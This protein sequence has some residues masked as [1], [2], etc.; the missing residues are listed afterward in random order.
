MAASNILLIQQGV[1]SACASQGPGSSSEHQWCWAL[2]PLL[3]AL[4]RKSM[5]CPLFISIHGPLLSWGDE[6]MRGEH[7][8]HHCVKDCSTLT[9]HTSVTE[10]EDTT[11]KTTQGTGYIENQ[12]IYLSVLK[13]VSRNLLLLLFQ[14]QITEEKRKKR[15]GGRGEREVGKEQGRGRLTCSSSRSL[16]HSTNSFREKTVH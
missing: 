16:S 9:A 8:W 1:K 14:S 4:W 5:Q 15:R 2:L 12:Q 10:S 6:G 13:T 11:V 7:L 3:H